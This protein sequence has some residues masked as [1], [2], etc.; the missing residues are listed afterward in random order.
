MALA[1]SRQ[2]DPEVEDLYWKGIYYFNKTTVPDFQRSRD[3]FERMLQKDPQNARAWTGVAMSN[4][5]LGPGAIFRASLS[6]K[7]P[8]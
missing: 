2:I 7:L 1:R 4:L 5:H 6:P 8:R 3:F